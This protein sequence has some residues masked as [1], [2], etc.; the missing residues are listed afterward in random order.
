MEQKSKLTL[1]LWVDL[2]GGHAS[3]FGAARS[4]QTGIELRAKGNWQVTSEYWQ[5]VLLFHQFH[6]L[7]DQPS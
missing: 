7:V 1:R 5:V 2:L 4:P 6:V 3:A